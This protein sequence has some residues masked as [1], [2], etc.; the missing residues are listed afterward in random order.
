MARKK[1]D[2]GGFDNRHYI[3]YNDFTD[4]SRWVEIL[5]AQP[6]KYREETVDIE[7]QSH[8]TG[9]SKG[10]YRHG[11]SGKLYEVI[12]LALETE[13]A[14][15]L[16]IYRPLYENEYELFARPVSMFTETVVLDGQSV[17]RFEN[18]NSETREQ[19]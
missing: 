18:V 3:E 17:P 11:K 13:T 19:V 15:L 6:G 14:E 4:D 7:K 12:G 5:R 8:H 10:T 2:N 1:Q 9:V 16:V